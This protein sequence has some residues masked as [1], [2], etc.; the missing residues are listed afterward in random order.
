MIKFPKTPRIKQVIEQE[1]VHRD[2]KHLNAVVQE[3]VDGA[4]TGISFSEEGQLL[5]QS[6]GHY[7]RGGP[8][9]RQFDLLKQWAN[10]NQN[11][12][13]DILEDKYVLFGEW[14][15]AKHHIFYDALPHYFLG[16]DLY[17]KETGKFVSLRR[18]HEI[19]R[20]RLHSVPVLAQG[21]FGKMSNFT[22]LIGPS[23]FQTKDWKK[24]F[25]EMAGEKEL[26]YTDPSG[27]MEG[28]YVRVEDDDWLIGRMKH[29]R[30]QFLKVRIDDSHWMT[31]PIIANQLI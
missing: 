28:V 2:W 18:Y 11:M 30:D 27:L 17:D 25:V 16:F 13:F 6:R 8:R 23:Q 7:L 24:K 1:C 29:P 15:Y 5:L 3:K 14:M 26:G 21:K 22:G 12:L 20:D 9:E 4:N 10:E 19:V 31:R